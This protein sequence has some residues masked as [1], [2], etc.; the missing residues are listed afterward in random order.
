[1]HRANAELGV[2]YRARV[3]ILHQSS[4]FSDLDG[5]Q[6]ELGLMHGEGNEYVVHDQAEAL[7]LYQL[8]AA[9]GHPTS[10]YL[11]AYCHERGIG[12]VRKNKAEAIRWYRSAQAAGDDGAAA[13]LQRLRA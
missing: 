4:S 7:R 8:A 9:Q 5:A 1:M 6:C 2:G 10:L 11:V 12:G 3:L 13:A